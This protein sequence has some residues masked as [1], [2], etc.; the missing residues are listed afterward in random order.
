M[1]GRKRIRTYDR[2]CVK[3]VLYQLSYT[4]PIKDINLKLTRFFLK[5]IYTPT[6]SK[7]GFS[8]TPKQFL[9][10]FN[11]PFHGMFFIEF[12]HRKVGIEK[13]GTQTQV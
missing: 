7:V 6:T 5:H 12:D 8:A 3:Q 11:L 4:P 13:S 2:L 1:D 9:K 10:L